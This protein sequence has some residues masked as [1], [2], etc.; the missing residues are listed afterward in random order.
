MVHD[1]YGIFE[2]EQLKIVTQN[3][4]LWYDLNSANLQTPNNFAINFGIV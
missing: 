1:F 4:L 2:T 3:V